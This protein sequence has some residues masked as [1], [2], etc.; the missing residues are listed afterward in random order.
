MTVDHLKMLHTA[1]GKGMQASPVLPGE[2]AWSVR[3]GQQA[4]SGIGAVPVCFCFGGWGENGAPSAAH[5][6]HRCLNSELIAPAQLVP[7]SAY[8][9]KLFQLRQP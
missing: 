1:G 9:S 4:Q 5:A 8:V 2:S 3:R 6:S 7:A